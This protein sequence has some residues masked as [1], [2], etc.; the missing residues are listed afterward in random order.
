LLSSR[1]VGRIMKAIAA[2]QG[3]PWLSPVDHGFMG[4]RPRARAEG[5]GA[6]RKKRAPRGRRGEAEEA[7]ARARCAPRA[8]ISTNS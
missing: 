2:R 4:M 3:T 7:E 8:D 5:I 6:D 1:L